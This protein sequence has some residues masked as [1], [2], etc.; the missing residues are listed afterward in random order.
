VPAPSYRTPLYPLTPIV[1]VAATALIIGSDLHDSGWKAWAGIGMAA[2]G[3]P[4][5]ALWTARRRTAA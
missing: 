2:L 4:V 5:Y 3:L 1:F